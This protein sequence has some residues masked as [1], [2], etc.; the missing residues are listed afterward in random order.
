M[1][2]FAIAIFSLLT[3]SGC[4][5][6]ENGNEEP[7]EEVYWDKDGIGQTFG[8][9]SSDFVIPTTAN[10][11]EYFFLEDKDV[12]YPAPV[13]GFCSIVN[14]TDG[15]MA[16]ERTTVLDGDHYLHCS[17]DYRFESYYGSDCY[18]LYFTKYGAIQMLSIPSPYLMDENF[19]FTDVDHYGDTTYFDEDNS[20][21]YYLD[22]NGTKYYK[23]MNEKTCLF[24]S[25]SVSI[26]TGGYQH[27]FLETNNTEWYAEFQNSAKLSLDEAYDLGCPCILYLPVIDLL[28]SEVEA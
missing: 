25:N 19:N 27:L 13:N 8:E 17:D 1:K 11:C 26:P 10:G 5:S 3:L 18:E 6:P 4:V 23:P 15:H 12:G 24:L 21:I 20:T 2:A 22:E 7:I 16:S 14:E 28:D 9:S